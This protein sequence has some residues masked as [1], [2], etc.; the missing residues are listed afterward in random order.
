MSVL[1]SIW[2]FQYALVP[3]LVAYVV[4]DFTSIIRQITRRLY[5]PVYFAFFP[6]GHSDELYARYLDEDSY[7]IVGGPFPED[8]RQYA[9]IKIIWLSVLSLMLTV[10]V[11][12]FVVSLFAHFTMTE[13]QWIQFLWTLFVVKLILLAK[14]LY[15]LSFHFKVIERVPFAYMIFLYVA[16]L[17]IILYN[18]VKVSAWL[19]AKLA[20]GGF[21]ELGMG[22]MD[23]LIF[24]IGYT[25]VLA[26]LLGFLVPWWLTKD[27]ARLNNE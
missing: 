8:Q 20:L 10:I 17:A 21:P 25:V 13:A 16:Y 1:D 27:V 18:T 19:N 4:F 23:F 6:F 14:S 15:D 2:S 3:C 11:N 5:V 9:R 24:D 22:I 12:P 7:Y 26:G